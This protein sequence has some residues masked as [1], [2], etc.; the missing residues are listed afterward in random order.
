MKSRKCDVCNIN[1]H[2][3]SNVKHLKSEK[4]IENE[5]IKPEYVFQEPI[6]NQN[7]NKNNPESLK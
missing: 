2:R 4:H 7:E 6:G 5:L 3:T 1:A